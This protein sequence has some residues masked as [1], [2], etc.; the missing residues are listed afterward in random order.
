M[1]DL[2]SAH[3]SAFILHQNAT[4]LLDLWLDLQ[5]AIPED[6]AA[7]TYF[8][9][10][11][12]MLLDLLRGREFTRSPQSHMMA[13]SLALR[14]HAV[15][16]EDYVLPSGLPSL[17]RMIDSCSPVHH[18]C[19]HYPKLISESLAAPVATDTTH[20]LHLQVHPS[21]RSIPLLTEA[22]RV[23]YGVT[24]QTEIQMT[25]GMNEGQKTVMLEDPLCGNRLRELV[26]IDRFCSNPP[27]HAQLIYF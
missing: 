24:Q 1:A 2:S 23:V 21:A 14:E 25:L 12:V 3:P 26:S 19:S 17:G 15:T 27:E 4:E 5:S 9:H 10:D 11:S 7:Y 22:L 8:L 18:L 6:Q 13:C 20:V 16:P